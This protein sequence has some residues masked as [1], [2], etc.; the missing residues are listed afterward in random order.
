MLKTSG[1]TKSAIQPGE[2]EF[3]VSG[4]NRTWRDRNK[5]DGSK[6]DS[7]EVDGG[8][9]KDDEIGKKVQKMSKFKNL[10]KSKKTVGSSDFLTPGARLVF[11]KLRQAFFKA[12]ILH[13]FDLKYYIRIKT[14]V[15][16][17]AIGGV[18][19]QLTLDD[20]S[21]WHLVAFFSWKMILTE[22]RYETPNGELLAIAEAFK[23]WR[24]YLKGSQHE[25]LM[26]TNHNN[27]QQFMDTKSLNSKQVRWA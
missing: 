14:D 12:L 20:L 8:E 15:L 5:L 3:E 2:G 26:L 22:T 13:H 23:T 27:L 18:F 7:G 16:G 10:S 6:L 21:W 17:Y 11:T 24:H 4:D 1:S 25:V 19:S 9:V